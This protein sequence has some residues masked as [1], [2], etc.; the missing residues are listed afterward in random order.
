VIT[1][2]HYFLDAVGGLAIMVIGYW[3]ARVVTRAGRRPPI[4]RRDRP[5]PPERVDGVG[6]GLGAPSP[7]SGA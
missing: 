4:D 5:D 7:A 3:L 6:G 2:N 1:G